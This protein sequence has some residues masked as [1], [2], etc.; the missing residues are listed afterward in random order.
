MLQ[1]CEESSFP[2]E[3]TECGFFPVAS[4]F[5]LPGDS[6]RDQGPDW[7]P[8]APP[9]PPARGWEDPKLPE[10]LTRD[11][12]RVQMDQWGVCVLLGSSAWHSQASAGVLVI[13]TV[14]KLKGLSGVVLRLWGG[15]WAS[16]RNQLISWKG[17]GVTSWAAGSRGLARE[18]VA[19]SG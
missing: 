7:E 16:S 6:K 18:E 10:H 11:G 1:E 13:V 17:G 2:R 19:G 14:V 3:A 15:A 8:G 12:G 4:P 9:Q 5:L